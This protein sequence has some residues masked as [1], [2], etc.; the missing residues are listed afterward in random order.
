MCNALLR[1][2]SPPGL[3]KVVGPGLL[4]AGKQCPACLSEIPRRASV[5]CS[6]GTRVEGVQCEACCL[7]CPEGARICCHCGSSLGFQ[8]FESLN[9]S[10]F[11]INADP[12]AT[13][14]LE[15]GLHPQRVRVSPDKLSIITFSL[16]GL[17]EN[18]EEV[19]WQKL[20]GFSH[21]SGLFWDSIKIETRGQTSAVIGCLSKRNA[22]RLKEV[23]RRASGLE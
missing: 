3:D 4:P 16:F 21:R 17:A 8:A 2:L 18:N 15:F 9:I 14:L 5:C 23:L 22:R 12:L 1:P 6:C 11:A 7:L 20:A 10:P 19:P 13:L